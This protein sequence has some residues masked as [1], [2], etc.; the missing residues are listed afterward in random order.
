M[1]LRVTL[2]CALA[3]SVSA[4]GRSGDR[5]QVSAVTQRFLQ[6]VR[7]H[8]GARACALLSTQTAQQVAQQ[9]GTSCRKAVV[10]LKVAPHAVTRVQVYITNAKVDLAGGESAF[11]E[12]TT[13]GWRLSAVGCTPDGGKPADRPYTCEAQA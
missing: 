9:A 13:N 6:A 2:V 3:L 7:D 1:L 4:C 11:A 8:D 12:L 10:D 5:G